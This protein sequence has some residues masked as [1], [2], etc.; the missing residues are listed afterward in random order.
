MLFARRTRLPFHLRLWQ[1]L[2]PPIGVP[3]TV[4]YCKLRLARLKGSPH[5]LALGLACGVFAAFVPLIGTQMALAAVVAYLVRAS[6]ATALIGTLVG[7]PLTYPAMWVA[8]Y[9]AGAT[10]IGIDGDI[11]GV[12]VVAG[13]DRLWDAAWSGSQEAVYHSTLALW[14]VFYPMLIGG[15]LLGLLAGALAYYMAFGVATAQQARRVVRALANA[16]G[17]IGAQAAGRENIG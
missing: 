12:A 10:L 2:W 6:L 7:T 9:A 13:A 15:V 8:S 1:A 17:A 11:N 16:E 14:P 5:A 3:R 4:R